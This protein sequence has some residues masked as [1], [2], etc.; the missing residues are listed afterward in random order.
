MTRQLAVR[1]YS[2]LFLTNFLYYY[3]ESANDLFLEIGK[4]GRA[5]KLIFAYLVIRSNLS[6]WQMG[7]VCLPFQCSYCWGCCCGDFPTN[8]FKVPLAR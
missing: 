7:N 4:S 3:F 1:A 6:L 5:K 8:N 2:F